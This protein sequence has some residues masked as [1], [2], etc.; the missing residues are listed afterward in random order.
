MMSYVSALFLIR[1]DDDELHYI[2]EIVYLDD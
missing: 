1:L 2:A